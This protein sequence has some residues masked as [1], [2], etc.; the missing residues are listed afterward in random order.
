M[1][2]LLLLVFSIFISGTLTQG[3]TAF[4]YYNIALVKYQIKDYKGAISDLDKAVEIDPDYSI[5]LNLRGASK[6]NLEDYEGALEDYNR[7]I[8]I[9]KRRV[10]RIGLTIYDRR[11]NVVDEHRPSET[12][13]G[14]AITFYNRAMVKSAIENYEEAIEDY[15][16][17]LKYDSDLVQV[18]LSRGLLKRELGDMEGAC[19]DWKLG[20]EHN[21][22]GA[23]ELLQVHCDQE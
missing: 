16:N 12:D 8:D 23:T 15:T 4:E 13:H 11:G 5:A 7:S 14:L 17:A 18:Y 22:E 3:Q 10:S 9:Q 19:S 2:N 20:E 6:F 21:V 1:K